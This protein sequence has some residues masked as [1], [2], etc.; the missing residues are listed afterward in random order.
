[1]NEWAQRRQRFLAQHEGTVA[2][3]PGAQT[4]LRNADTEYEFRQNSDFFYLTNF[5]EPEALAVLSSGDHPQFT[6]FVRPRD[7]A[8]ETWTGRRFGIEGAL[9]HFQADAAYPIEELAAR[10][11]KLLTGAETLAYEL[12]E[13][14][15]RDRL[16]LNALREARTMVRRGGQAPQ[17]FV[18]P[19]ITLHEMR[20]HKSV[21]ELETLRRAAAI[22]AAG[23]D[24]GYRATR[25]GLME[26]QLEAIIEAEYR[27]LGA[28]DVAYPSIVAG[29]I[30]ATI[31]H[32]N[33]NRE[34]L[35]DNELVL[36]DSGCEL[37]NYAS[38]VTRTWPVNGR[39]SAEQRAVYEIVLAAQVASEAELR[40]GRPFDAYHNASVRVITEGLRELGIIHGNL[41]GLIEDR[42][43][44]PFYMHRTGHWLGLD[45]HD[46][47]RYTNGPL[48]R[49]LV[50]NMVL[51]VEPGIYISP[52]S[53][54][55]QRFRGIGI[56][57][58][59]DIRITENGFENLTLAIPKTIADLESIIGDMSNNA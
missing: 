20:L 15:V 49:S 57:I 44:L 16:I 59:D 42:A 9:D 52:D 33:T 54:V 31:L 19:G 5:P 25:P 11:P 34:Q 40:A 2:I 50:P 18:A 10:L 12:G 6:L 27:S 35:R 39:F 48:Y 51:T 46:A 38:D 1:M 23:F 53:D 24:K 32:Y 8:A 37:D 28:Q 30:N 29:G 4:T 43:Y 13:N 56:R 47:G 7:R 21:S 58:E 3:I 26:Y 14:E 41:D 17:R 45:V 55:D 22:T 36:V